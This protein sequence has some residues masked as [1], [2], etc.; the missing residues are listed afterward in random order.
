MVCM[1][2]RSSKSTPTST[3]PEILRHLKRL[4]SARV[5]KSMA[6][7]GIED[8]T[9]LG[10]SMGTIQSYAKTLGRNH[11]RALE[12]WDSGGYEARMVAIY[13]ADPGE[14]TVAQMN[15][16]CRDF[17]NWGTCDTACWVLFDKSPLAW[18]RLGPWSRQQEEHPKRAAFA[19]LAG[20]ALHDRETT[21]QRFL[22]TLKLIKAGA[23]DERHFVK[24][25]VNWALRAIGVRS[26]PLLQACILLA[27]ELEAS[28]LPSARWVGKDALR[29]F[30]TPAARK[31]V[32]ARERKRKS[33]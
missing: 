21:D 4:G 19:L 16:W 2:E 15:R 8:P 28:E 26:E 23:Q 30:A 1:A 14:L 3:V 22:S 29:Y 13:T 7:F 11:S 18:G 17:R 6:R 31:R 10:I 12:L 9:A 32:A 25:G 20:L 5:R 33:D 24:K 27:R